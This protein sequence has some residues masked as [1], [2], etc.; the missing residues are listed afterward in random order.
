MKAN[1]P[2]LEAN[3]DFSRGIEI[4][5][6]QPRMRTRNDK[7]NQAYEIFSRSASTLAS[8]LY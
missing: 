2:I 8:G 4:V 6:Q 3:H 1:W 5:D 7:E